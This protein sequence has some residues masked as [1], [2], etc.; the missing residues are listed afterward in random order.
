MVH[1]VQ[2][3]Y[4]LVLFVRGQDG[5]REASGGWCNHW[6]K[7]DRSSPSSGYNEGQESE[8]ILEKEPTDTE[9]GYGQYSQFQIV[10]V[11]TDGSL[12]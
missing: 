5:N 3:I 2:W 8:Y 9:H 7:N 4:S 11:A 10:S 6:V 1:K 12:S